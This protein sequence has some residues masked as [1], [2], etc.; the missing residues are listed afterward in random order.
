MTDNQP[1]EDREKLESII[2]TLATMQF[3]YDDG[4]HTETMPWRMREQLQEYIFELLKSKERVIRAEERERA[5]EI[6][7]DKFCEVFQPDAFPVYA[8]ME[9]A[10][11]QILSDNPNTNE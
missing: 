2:S 1:Q 3:H 4:P 8:T 6:M 11:R 9:S 5:A 7:R 10:R